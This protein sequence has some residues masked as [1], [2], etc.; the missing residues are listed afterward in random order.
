MTV[1]DA[2]DF[3]NHKAVHFV[4]DAETGLRAIIAMHDTT[5]GPALGGLRMFDYASS[6]N[7]VT[8]VLRLSRGMTFKNALAGIPYGGGKAVILGNPKTDKSPALMR[9]LGRA[10]D[11]LD[12]AYITAEDVGTTVA[13]MDIL[14]TQTKY[15]RGTSTGVG[16]PSPYTARGVAHAIRCAVR[17][18][19]QTTDLS[20]IRVAIQ[21]LGNV[22]RH[23]AEMLH[24]E[25]AK[26]VVTDIDPARLDAA[27]EDLGADVVE[28]DA[29]YNADV[30]IFAPCAMGAAINDTTLPQLRAGI[31]CGAANNQLATPT[32]GAALADKGILY[33]P[34]FVANAGG[35]INIGLEGSANDVEITQR[36]DGIAATV[37]EIL[38]RSRTTGH[39]PTD[40]AETLARERIAAAAIAA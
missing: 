16:D 2:A 8:D 31:I 4:S 20:G 36:V 22:G 27:A 40:V 5:L 13:D 19:H 32:H 17:E 6:D 12:G 3:D 38:T 37:T 9:A 15:A 28:I 34:D 18:K 25:G 7:A 10:I 1:F 35:V 23:L 33:V 14:R 21:G 30:D 39:L 11:R 26:L 24:A 29:I